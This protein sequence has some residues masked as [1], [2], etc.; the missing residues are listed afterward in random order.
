MHRTIGNE[1][2]L[3]QDT[4]A[5]TYSGAL[6]QGSP[7]TPTVWHTPI[8]THPR[9]VADIDP[10]STTIQPYRRKSVPTVP[11]VA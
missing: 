8:S 10:S 5:P 1:L 2:L 11:L 3:G 6:N 7:T 9:S 4:K